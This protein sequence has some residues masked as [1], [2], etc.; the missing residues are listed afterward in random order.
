MQVGVDDALSREQ[1]EKV[2]DIVETGT[3]IASATTAAAIG[4]LIG[5]PP[6]AIVGA[7]AGPAAT[8]TLRGLAV[9]FRERVLGH[10]EEVRVGATI[11]FAS[12]K[13]KEKLESGEWPRQDDFF[14]DAEDNRSTAKEVFEGVVLAAQ[15]EAEEKKV[16]LYG[17]LLANLAFT[18]DVD[19]SQAN[20]L[21]RLGEDLSYR[22]LCLLSLFAQNTL[23]Q[24]GNNRLSL[25]TQDYRSAEAVSIDLIVLLQE[26]YDLYQRGIVGNGGDA[27]ISV[28]DANP[29]QMSPVGAAA[30]LY[31][32]MELWQVSDDDL[33]ALILLLR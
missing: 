33:N 25:R 2:K 26:M 27:M 11:S 17:N 21:I 23:L 1:E 28:T 6:G 15:R 9:E 22:Q 20:F 10:R 14:T 3:D 16:R 31:S 12:A 24:G 8:R 18:Q 19:R 7:A 32:L 30:N 13:I 29:S 5:G 4:L